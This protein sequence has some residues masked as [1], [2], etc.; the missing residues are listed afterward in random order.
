M[1][2]QI[3]VKNII[4][5][6]E[7]LIMP[8]SWIAQMKHTPFLKTKITQSESTQKRIPEQLYICQKR[9]TLIKPSHAE[10][11]RPIDIEVNFIKYVKKK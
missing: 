10:N 1:T 11:S 2:L 8:I 3:Y 5:K 4:R 9:Q 7:E 6:H